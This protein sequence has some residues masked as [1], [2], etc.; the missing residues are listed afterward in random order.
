MA[1]GG[2]DS[3]LGFVDVGAAL[4]E[5]KVHLVSCV[6]ALHLQ[7]RRVLTLVPQAALVASE[8]GLTPQSD[9]SNKGLTIKSNRPRR[10]TDPVESTAVF[11]QF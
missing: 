6:A 7:E 3:L 5:V 9:E 8:D 4:A 10:P 2:R 11:P 1:A